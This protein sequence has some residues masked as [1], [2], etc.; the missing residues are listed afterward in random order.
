MTKNN[1]NVFATPHCEPVKNAIVYGKKTRYER[2]P[3]IKAQVEGPYIH[4]G[5]GATV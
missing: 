1:R 4:I 5:Y 3:R 2:P